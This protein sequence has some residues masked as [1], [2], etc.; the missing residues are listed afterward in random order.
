VFA[1]RTALELCRDRG[2]VDYVVFSD[3]QG[4]V[5]RFGGHPVEWRSREELRLPNDFFDK[6][7][8][9]A[10]Y[11]RRTVGRVSKRLAAQPHQIEA[12][13]L[14]NAPHKEFLLSESALW[15]R[16]DRDAV[17]HPKTLGLD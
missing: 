12:F 6:V 1:I 2:L 8:G 14:F 11:L 3:C 13:E 5:R 9:R 7:L 15:G 10:S 17:R 4:A 16:V